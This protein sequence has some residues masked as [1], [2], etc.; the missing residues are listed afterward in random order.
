MRLP[1]KSEI[2]KET[3]LER[4]NTILEGVRLAKKVDE[5]RIELLKE[6]NNLEKLRT[7]TRKALQKEIDDLFAQRDSLTHENEILDRTNKLLKE[8]FDKEWE[9][10]HEK[11]MQELN[12]NADRIEKAKI[13][14]EAENARIRALLI[15]KEKDGIAAKLALNEAHRERMESKNK[16]HEATEIMENAQVYKAEA[17]SKIDADNNQLEKKKEE[18]ALVLRDIEVREASLARASAQLAKRDRFINS[19]YKALM[20]AQQQL[21][22]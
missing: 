3:V 5:V 12:E 20:N 10:L 22:K 1:T 15:Q 11:R 7:E 9:A 21:K 13:A 19:K 18:L 14:I 17:Q 2:E 4:Q 16:L 6:K 8:P